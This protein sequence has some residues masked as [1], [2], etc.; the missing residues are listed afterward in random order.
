MTWRDGGAPESRSCAMVLTPGES[1]TLWPPG[2]P[3]VLGIASSGDAAAMPAVVTGPQLPRPIWSSSRSGQEPAAVRIRPPRSF[4]ELHEA[5]AAARERLDE[6]SRAAEAVAAAASS[7]GNSRQRRSRTSSCAPRSTP[8]A[9]NAMSWAKPGR[10]R[11]R[12]RRV[13]Q[14]AEQATASAQEIDQERLRCAG[15]TRSSIPVCAARAKH[16][17]VQAEGR[18]T[19]AALRARIEE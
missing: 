5:L 2:W 3:S 13:D 11:R 4:L 15:R 12:G 16:D 17:Q 9:P 19:Q 7:S 18:K 6:L 1:P 8:C 10:W 14:E